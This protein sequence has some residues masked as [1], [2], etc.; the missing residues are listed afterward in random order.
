MCE[1]WCSDVGNI[2]GYFWTIMIR[3]WWSGSIFMNRRYADMSDLRNRNICL[4]ASFCYACDNSMI[5]F[6]YKTYY[7]P[8][9]S[10][11]IAH[12][13][14]GNVTEFFSATISPNLLW[15]MNKIVQIDCRQ[16][17][18]T[19]FVYESLGYSKYS[20]YISSICI[21]YCMFIVHLARR[22]LD[23]R[24]REY[25]GMHRHDQKIKNAIS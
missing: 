25:Q 23:G 18:R 24:P 22:T 20:S 12:A 14:Y 9:V 11:A 17:K 2:D 13:E 5:F 19:V 10:M 15:A 4:D 6:V 1:R 3:I 16:L 21:I 7:V 8:I